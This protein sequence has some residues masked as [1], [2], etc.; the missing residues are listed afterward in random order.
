LTQV[1]AETAACS[2]FATLR[3]EEFMPMGGANESAYASINSFV[4][5]LGNWLR[6]RRSVG[7]DRRNFG[8]WSDFEI[9][10]IAQDVGLSSQDLH[11]M[12]QLSPD[13]A[14]LLLR[15]MS[16]LQLDADEL[17]KSEMNMMRDLQRVCSTCGSKRQCRI[18]LAD[19][20]ENQVWRRYCPNEDTLT[21]LQSNAAAT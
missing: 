1:N 5:A 6:K 15:R 14:K 4:S 10:R 12:M 20:P 13:A 9:A 2:S 21:E 7:E 11:E 3:E 17:A 8:E 16:V 18:D 19:D